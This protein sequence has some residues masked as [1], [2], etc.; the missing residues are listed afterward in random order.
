MKQPIATALMK[1]T[2]SKWAFVWMLCLCIVRFGIAQDVTKVS[3]PSWTPADT[4]RIILLIQ[5]GS[6]MLY[7]DVDSALLLLDQAEQLSRST[8][9]EDGIGYALAFTGMAYTYK[10]DYKS[11]FEAYRKALPY[12]LN[13]KHITTALPSL[14]INIGVSYRGN[15]NYELANYYYFKALQYLQQCCPGHRDIV[16]IY[17]NLAVVQCGLKNHDRALKYARSAVN[18]STA[19]KNKSLIASSKLNAGAIYAQVRQYDSARIFYESAL[20]AATD[21]GHT[22][23]Q[24]AI[25]TNI[26]NLFLETGETHEAIACYR[27]AIRISQ[28]THLLHS[29]IL[30]SYAL[31]K[32]LAQLKQYGEAEEILRTSIA[33]AEKAGMTTSRHDA[34]KTLAEIYETTGRYKEALKQ[35][36]AYQAIND[37]LANAERIR[38]ISEVETRYL[39]GQKDKQIAENKL[40]LSEQKRKLEK[41][42]ILTASI[43]AFGILCATVAVI[44]YQYRRKI[45]KRNR[46]MSY[47]K[48]VIAGEE[49]ERDRIARELHDGFGGMLTGMQLRI[50]ALVEKQHA[51]RED[52]LQ[53][54][55]AASDIGREIHKTAR[56]LTPQILQYYNLY[57][58]LL[59]YCEQFEANGNLHINLEFMGDTDS[60]EKS[61]ELSLYR[62]IQELVQNIAKHARAKNAAIQIRSEGPMLYISVEDDGVGFS[63]SS[64]RKGLGLQH[65]HNRI[66]AMNG[67]CTIESSPGRG[68][69]VFIEINR[70]KIPN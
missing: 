6:G 45:E 27:E 38:T 24:Q 18:L 11:S 57:E 44:V 4:T 33:R 34:H 46:D 32:A 58:A 54:A 13:A 17:N 40:E 10:G 48:A 60:L 21:A 19:L 31:G 5:N 16:T 25:L 20:Q 43:I 35:Y 3:Y 26:G 61:L 39:V 62:I 2:I 47:M 15:G 41:T 69:A 64:A 59:H 68:T 53:L 36:Q 70:N 50:G 23:K 37:S 29:S 49:K 7:R 28:H 12:C 1:R 66:Q 67:Y 63:T 52:L 56:N 14:Y 42:R 9:F 30:P 22:D 51:T 65:V 55:D 8:G